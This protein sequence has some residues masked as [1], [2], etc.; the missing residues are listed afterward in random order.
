MTAR[1]EIRPY[2]TLVTTVLDKA[3]AAAAAANTEAAAA[4]AAAPAEAEA[5]QA[6]EVGLCNLNPVYPALETT[7][8]QPLIL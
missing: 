1:G 3:T 2:E 7:W 5:A 6:A 4:P 8:F